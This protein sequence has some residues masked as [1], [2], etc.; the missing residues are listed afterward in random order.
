ME[1]LNI[2]E[3]GL[4]RQTVEARLS[5]LL[6]TPG[7]LQRIAAQMLSPL[8]RDLLFEGRMRQVFQTYKL[9][10]GE[11]AYFDADV[12]V[13]AAG[14]SV[15]G[16]PVELEVKSD[17]ILIMTSPISVKTVIRWNESNYRKFD[18]LNR[19]QERAKASIQFQEDVRGYKLLKF[20]S[21]LT[22]QGKVRSLEGT[23]AESLN[24]SIIPETSGKLSQ[25]TLV[26]AITTLRSK[27]LVASKILLNPLRVK[28]LML[29]NTTISGTGGAGIFAPNFQEQLL[30]AGKVG[31]I[32][33]CEVIDNVVV[34]ANEVYVLAPADYLGVIAVRTDVS[35]ETLRDPNQMGDVFAIWEDVGFAVRYAKG[36]VRID[37]A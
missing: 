37:V 36:I 4:D 14:I 13:P 16:L 35:I 7:G 5:R 12:D 25:E 11:E 34:P 8:K 21:S 33:G 24:P 18:I 29:F 31:S 28:D 6:S 26:T 20:A 32:W 22:N 30:K 19:T 2:Y 27:L 23:T 9:S 15:E 10:Q 3:P 17:R 1:N